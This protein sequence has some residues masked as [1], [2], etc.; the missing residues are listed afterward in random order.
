MRFAVIATAAAA[1]VAVPLA[2]SASGPHMSSDQ[3]LTAVRCTAYQ[4]ITGG[5]DLNDA[6]WQLNAEARRQP[7][8]TVARAEAEVSD[9]VLKTASVEAGELAQEQVA[10]CSGTQL[11]TAPDSRGDA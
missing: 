5:H 8:E 9:I 4:D 11:A 3:F 2:V 7:A 10:A 1:A 6:K